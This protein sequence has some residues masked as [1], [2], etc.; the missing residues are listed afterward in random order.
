[1]KKANN[2][3][4]KYLVLICLAISVTAIFIFASTL[5]RR[6]T[7]QEFEER[8]KDKCNESAQVLA[9]SLSKK[10]ET[11]DSIAYIF[12]RQHD[13]DSINLELLDGIEKASGFDYVRFVDDKGNDHTAD[14]EVADVSDR[15]YVKDGLSG[16]KGITDV[17]ISRVNGE[18][19]VGF[20]TPI[21]DRNEDICGV[22]VGFMNEKRVVE[23]VASDIDGT[24]IETFILDHNGKIIDYYGN[25]SI[26]IDNDETIKAL[27]APNYDEILLALSNNDSYF[28]ICSEE[29]DYLNGC[30]YPVEGTDWS[31][32]QLMPR[33][34]PQRTI[35]EIEKN[36]SLILVLFVLSFMI[37]GSAYLGILKRE[38]NYQA[39]EEGHNRINAL[40]R[41]SAGDYVALIVV[42]LETEQEERFQLDDTPKLGDWSH[43]NN[44]YHYCIREYANEYVVDEDYD[45]FISCTTLPVLKDYLKN[46]DSYLI[47]Y[48][49]RL[50]DGIHH[51]LGKFSI[52]ELQNNQPSLLISICDITNIH[53]EKRARETEI[54][55][56]ATAA[57]TVYQFIMEE[58]LTTDEA[59]IIHNSGHIKLSTLTKATIAEVNEDG[60]ST[61]PTAKEREEF[62]Q[63]FSRENLLKAYENGDTELEYRFRQKDELGNIHWMKSYNIIRENDFGDVIC[64]SLTKSIDEDIARE[65]ELSRAKEAA[66]AANKAKSTFLFNMSHDI[67]TP[68]NAIIGFANLAIRHKDNNEKLDHYLGNILK[69]SNNLLDLINNV[70]DMARIEAGKD[71][72]AFQN[73]NVDDFIDDIMVTFEEVAR[74][75]DIEIRVDLDIKHHNV[76]TDALKVRQIYLNVL[77]NAVKY[78]N[79]GGHINIKLVENDLGDD[80]FSITTSICD[81]GVGMSEE[82]LPHIFDV[83]ERER[84]TAYSNVI[85]SGLGMGIVKKMIDL[86]DGK[87]EVKSELGAGT[88]VIFE[89]KVRPTEDSLANDSDVQDI[90]YELFKGK[91][92]L[93]T[94]DNDFNAEI[95]NDLLVEAGFVVERA[96][97][98][99]E[100]VKMAKE[101]RYDVIIMD[102]QM[103]NM[104]GY[105]AVKI[106]RTLDE[107]NAKV[108]II[109]MTANAFRIDRINAK[110]AGMDGHLSKPLDAALLLSKLQK[111]LTD[112]KE[113][114]GS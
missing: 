61:I 18:R 38:R 91:R 78:T 88:E 89:I 6:T 13:S 2:N 34:I 30:S 58:N 33:S 52:A 71:S 8:I 9:R 104:N 55:L 3:L 77:S 46:H 74:E 85:G 100:A 16:N 90:D 108:P 31:I 20:Y 64:I 10:Q 29:S 1:M 32:V 5:F 60:A 36:E 110:K 59:T 57:S 12:G 83:F 47:E 70:L 79:N 54:E 101:Y 80:G 25:E 92:I 4:R 82:F 105:E 68:M 103:P 97:D 111:L 65:E 94:E 86:L 53:E 69:S 21:Y 73:I 102:I 44:D 49:V 84:N 43:G 72:L 66:D 114:A 14:G 37:F 81:D 39:E 95:A 113:A 40:L 50:R 75:K 109:A 56:I 96:V 99:V 112:N 42:D 106:I 45:R 107:H 93:L 24:R 51:F 48:D 62:F 28:F 26:D 23:A 63:H 41:S 7:N 17:L 19:I 27:L 98:G 35:S 22:M 11:L 67:R 87:I 76:I 15:D